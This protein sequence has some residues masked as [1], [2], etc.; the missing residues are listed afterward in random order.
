MWREKKFF[1]WGGGSTFLKYLTKSQL[2]EFWK[3][4][5]F[6][7]CYIYE[8]Y[9]LDDNWQWKIPQEIFYLLIFFLQGQVWL[10]IIK[11]TGLIS[12]VWTQISP[13]HEALLLTDSHE[14]K[15]GIFQKNPSQPE[16]LMLIREP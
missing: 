4:L 13:E 14:T 6:E 10:L 9:F 2:F 15:K 5:N 16:G 8:E 1:F 11:V 7:E 3:Y 12:F